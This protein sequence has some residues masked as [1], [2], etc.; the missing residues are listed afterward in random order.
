MYYKIIK[1]ILNSIKI[2]IKKNFMKYNNK[3][4]LLLLI[5]FEIFYMIY[6]DLFMICIIFLKLF[7]N[8]NF[9]NKKFILF[10]RNKI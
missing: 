8:D 4:I 10:F 2:F 7:F 1:R 5:I 9:Y 3:I 6:C